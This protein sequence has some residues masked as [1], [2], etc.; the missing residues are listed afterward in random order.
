VSL[1]A[2]GIRIGVTQETTVS[3][4]TIYD[5]RYTGISVGWMW[6]PRS[7]VARAPKII[8]NDIGRCTQVLSDGGGI[9]TLGFK[10]DPIRSGNFTQR[11]RSEPGPRVRLTTGLP[12]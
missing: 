12:H 1:G 2:V 9:Y 11:R 4:S 10:P 3:N 5:V 8:N 7:T 6:N